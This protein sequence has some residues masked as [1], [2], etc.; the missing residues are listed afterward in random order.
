MTK[1]K[2]KAGI[3]DLERAKLIE[4]RRKALVKD[5]ESSDDVRCQVVSFF[6]G[7]RF[8]K[9]TSLKIRDVRLVYAPALG[10][11]NFGDED[12]ARELLLWALELDEHCL[13]AWLWLSEVAS[14]P[15]SGNLLSWNGAGPSRRRRACST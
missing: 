14:S 11:G 8:M 10:V 13:T 15:R 4:K 3:S 6:G 2:M 1:R 9:L 7:E 12:W 5:C